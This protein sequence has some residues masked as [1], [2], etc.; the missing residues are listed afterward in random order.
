MDGQHYCFDSQYDHQRVP[1]NRRDASKT[2]DDTGYME[3]ELTSKDNIAAA[4]GEFISSNSSTFTCGGIIPVYD[5]ASSRA[6]AIE[7]ASSNIALAWPVVI[8]WD[9]A[10]GP[11]VPVQ[12]PIQDA[13]QAAHLD[14][15]VQSCDPAGFG[16]GNQDVMDPEY[17]TA[18]KM[19]TSAFS[20][21]L[22]PYALGIMDQVTRML[23]PNLMEYEKEG[24]T[25]RGIVVAELYK[26]NVC[27]FPIT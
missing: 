23:L 18:I 3:A 9:A 21:N 10:S 16:R 2:E 20:T 6:A 7:K 27:H 13:Q 11:G 17:R 24:M 4:L 19:D 22:C 5:S 12:F 25:P 1:F 26:L 15:L 14:N 8:R